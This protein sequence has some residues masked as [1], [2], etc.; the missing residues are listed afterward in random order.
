MSVV[1]KAFELLHLFT[2]D[3]PEL[4]L[5]ELH[6]LAGRDKAT[7]F[8]HLA[9]LESVGL[10]ERNPATRAY[11][12]GPAVIRLARLREAGMPRREVAAAA[13]DRLA[14]LT[15]E[16][17]HA[18][19]LAGTTLLSLVVRESDLHSNRV[20]IRETE[21]PLHA[22]AS[23]LAVLA[24]GPPALR[25]AALDRA[26]RFTEATLVTAPALDAAIAAAR[27]EGF[28]VSAQ[29]FEAGVHGTAA[30][31]FDETGTAAGAVAVAAPASR[32]T[33]A[34]SR[35][36]RQGLARAAREITEG[37]GGTVPAALETTWA[38]QTALVPQIERTS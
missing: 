6:R 38:R 10:L 36:I 33:P 5:S 14:A 24:F 20:V 16:T 26:E 9:A 19:A 18:S 13:L 7:T 37:W 21:L 28:S 34:L 29:G 22:T 17:A 30:P 15:G 35:T 3:R 27:A 31:V 32:M 12:I 4:G 25:A 2:A 8:R 1:V 23:G 11:R